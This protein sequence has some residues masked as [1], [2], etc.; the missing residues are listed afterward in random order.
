M[1]KKIYH[2]YS[3]YT[4]SFGCASGDFQDT[5]DDVV[6]LWFEEATGNCSLYQKVT[7][8]HTLE[9]RNDSVSIKASNAEEAGALAVVFML[10]SSRSDFSP[11]TSRIFGEL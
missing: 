5:E 6:L 8:T 3:S 7:N 9:E 2:K 10:D 11:P 1:V 4:G